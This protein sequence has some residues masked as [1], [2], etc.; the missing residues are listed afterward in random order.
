MTTEAKL[1]AADNDRDMLEYLH[2]AFSS[3]VNVCDNC[4]HETA[5][6]ECDSASDLRDYLSNFPTLP[7]PIYN[8]AKERELFEASL[9]STLVS[10]NTKGDYL[11]VSSRDKWEGWKACAQSRAK[12]GEVGHE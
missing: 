7:Q 10:L 12:A 3:Q 5:T 2:D 8:E 11:Y 6:S 4:G 9:G 1:L